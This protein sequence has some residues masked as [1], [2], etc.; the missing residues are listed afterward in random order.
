MEVTKF[1]LSKSEAVNNQ[2]L[3]FL[4]FQQSYGSSPSSGSIDIFTDGSRK[5]D[6]T[7]SAFY[8]PFTIPIEK[9]WRLKPR[10]SSLVSEIMAINGS[11]SYVVKLDL[12]NVSLIRLF[13]DCESALNTI[14]FGG[15]STNV[16]VGMIRQKILLITRAG[17]EIQLIWIPSHAGIDGNE[18]A[19]RLAY[20]ATS[21]KKE[22]PEAFKK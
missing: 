12:K 13:C 11:L 22:Q 14:A 9:A 10:S 4:L 19:D 16:V 2:S 3:T 21:S 7:S 1:P 18:R 20:R 6:I 8:I 5:K 17:V 15:R